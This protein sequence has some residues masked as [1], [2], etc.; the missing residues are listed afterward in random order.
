M[1]ISS[2]MLNNQQMAAKFPCLNATGVGIF[3]LTANISGVTLSGNLL[4]QI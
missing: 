3:P 4:D 1:K 2:N